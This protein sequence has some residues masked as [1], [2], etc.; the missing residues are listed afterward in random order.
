MSAIELLSPAGNTELALAAFDGGA[1]AVYCGLGNF[2]ARARAENF[3]ADSL[4]RLLRFAHENGKK[5]YVTFNTLIFESELGAMFE[6]L[7]E[8]SK[9]RPD[10]LIVQD[11]GVAWTVRKYFPEL[12]LHASTQMGIHNS[13]G[14]QCAAK[15]GF[16]RVILERQVTM[17]ELRLLAK[18]SPVELEVF[19]HGSLCC[20]LSGRCLLSGTLCHA[21]G[22]RGQCRQ[23]CRKLYRP[24]SQRGGYWLSPGDLNGSTL[25]EEFRNLKIASLK[26]E[27]RLRTP[28]YVWKTARAYRMLLD[29]PGDPAAHRESA[30]LL[31]AA[32]SRKSGTAFYHQHNWNSLIDPDASGVFGEAAAEVKQSLRRGV[33]V[34][35]LTSLHLGDRLRAGSDGKS[36]SLTA[37][38]K[39]RGK[40]TL[41][42]GAGEKVFIPGSFQL[43]PGEKLLRIGENGFDFSRRA[44]SLPEFRHRLQLTIHAAPHGFRGEIAG[45]KGEWHGPAAFARADRHPLTA[46][47]VQ[48]VFAEGAP[49]AFTAAGVKVT[50]NGEFF[51]PAAEL[52]ALRRKF[53]EF[54]TPILQQSDLHAHIA[55]KMA[56]F[57]EDY[58]ELNRGFP[59]ENI[60]EHAFTVPPF[61]PE[62]E[63]EMCRQKI[64]AA[65]QQGI[66]NFT[67]T[68]WHAPE[69][70]RELPDDAVI[71]FDFPFPVTNSLAVRMAASLGANSVAAAPETPAETLATIRD[72]APIAVHPA[73]A[74]VPLLVTRLPLPPGRWSDRDGHA[75]KVLRQDGVSLLFTLAPE[76]E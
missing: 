55:V 31:R 25:L 5:V 30:A 46:E 65:Y 26:I 66:R 60:P 23:L 35:V 2:N 37:M 70:L 71:H 42:A 44:G 61:I 39:V 29:S 54:F 10:A 4:G 48:K 36:F 19:V 38:E 27:G 43:A 9:L 58:Q 14:L 24:A 6:A 33:L 75:F 63:L 62:T 34:N 20:S 17:D 50:V 3:T 18:N 64:A 51:V 13:A 76:E 74:N 22:N 40:R 7:A 52:K 1:D 69:L 53:W 47:N 21:S 15:C 41:R 67:A 49:A 12:T 28:D 16:K 56:E 32:V 8:L 11:P 45:I 73:S 72:H 59:A 68:H 57:F